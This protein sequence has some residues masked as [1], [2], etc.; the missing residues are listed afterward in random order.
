MAAC[1]AIGGALARVNFAT[2]GILISRSEMSSNAKTTFIFEEGNG[3]NYHKKVSRALCSGIF[4][5]VRSEL[6]LSSVHMLLLSMATVVVGQK[7][8]ASAEN[9]FSF[10]T[11][12]T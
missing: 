10:V 2:L 5:Q 4:D 1:Q 7:L 12:A 11:S 9:A 6:K 3:Y 8:R